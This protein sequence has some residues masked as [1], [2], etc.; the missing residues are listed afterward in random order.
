MKT[1][2][3]QI[4]NVAKSFG[5]YKTLNNLTIADQGFMVLMGASGCGKSTLLRI[6]AGLETA[7]SGE[8]WISGK[9][10]APLS[11][12]SGPCAC[13]GTRCDFDGR[14]AVKP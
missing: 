13:D 2:E 10:I 4:K 1:T 7:N 6:I 11:P 9:R 3:I 8:V 5:A 14:A 12:K